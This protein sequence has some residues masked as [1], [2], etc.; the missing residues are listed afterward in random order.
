MA[1]RPSLSPSTTGDADL[2]ALV[3]SSLRRG[4]RDRLAVASVTPEGTQFAGFGA[5]ENTEFEIG[6]ITKTMTGLLLAEAITRGEVT[7]NTQLGELLDMG[8]S[9]TANATLGALATHHSGLPALGGTLREM[10][11]VQWLV[12]QRADP[13]QG[14]DYDVTLRHGRDA[15]LSSPKFVYSNLGFALLGHALAAAADTDWATLVRDRVFAPAG[16]SRARVPQLRQ[17]LREAPAGSTK[18]GRPAEPW[19][20]EGYA[21]A[22][23]V[24]AGMRDMIAYAQYL[25]AGSDAVSTTLT[26]TAKVSGKTT[27][28][29]AWML[30]PDGTAWHNGGT[31]GFSSILLLDPSRTR[32]VIALSNTAVEVDSLGGELAKRLWQD[33]TA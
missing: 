31:G 30:E 5:D 14:L 11:R 32:V 3:R 27:I 28:G 8:D 21:P 13:Y 10:L 15:S 24:R 20:L 29:Y 6:S 25:L 9:E 12:M 7:S 22:G 2:V 26:G 33:N 16:M 4:T 19:L 17:D 23:V 1:R 18:S